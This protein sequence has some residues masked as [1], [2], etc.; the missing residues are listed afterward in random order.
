M[1]R[2]INQRKLE[3]VCDAVIW[4]GISMISLLDLLFLLFYSLWG[5]QLI[6]HPAL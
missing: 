5:M 1:R 4:S 3:V 6:I 2:Y